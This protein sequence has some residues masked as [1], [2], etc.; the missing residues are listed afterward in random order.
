DGIKAYVPAKDFE[1]P[2]LHEAIS[3]YSIA[4]NSVIITEPSNTNWNE[5][6]EKNYEPIQVGD[7]LYI[8]AS[9]HAPVEGVREIIIDP[10]MSFGTGH[11]ATTRLC[12][13]A[14]FETDFS[15]KKVLDM[16]TG[17]GILAILASMLGAA[18]ITA[19]DNFP[20]AV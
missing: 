8:R 14:A 2:Q 5:E 7:K 15:N 16:G 11:H 20:T 6:W 10:K 18:D 12:S 19:V 3:Q 9:F 1:E 17:T 13:L 4:K